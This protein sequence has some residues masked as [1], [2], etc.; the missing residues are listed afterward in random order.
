MIKTVTLGHATFPTAPSIANPNGYPVID[1]GI[2]HTVGTSVDF[3]SP[4]N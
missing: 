4:S 3:S 2:S 1:L